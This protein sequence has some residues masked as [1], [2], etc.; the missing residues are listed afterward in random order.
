MVRKVSATKAK[1]RFGRLLEEVAALGRVHIV[2]HGRIA[3][4]V[5]SPRALEALLAVERERG[6]GIQ[7][8]RR[9]H[10]I[11]VAAA[12]AARVVKRGSFDDDD[13]E[14]W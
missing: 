5:L 9:N 8:S 12:R 1:N 2:K 11:P 14:E 3:A 7:R 4:I 6:E 10:M 13:E